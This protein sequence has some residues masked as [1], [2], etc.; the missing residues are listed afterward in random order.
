MSKNYFFK[1]DKILLEYYPEVTTIESIL[2]QLEKEEIIYL[3][4]L[5]LEKRYIEHFGEDYIMFCIGERKGNYYYLN[6]NIFENQYDFMYHIDLVEKLDLKLEEKDFYQG[7]FAKVI[8]LISD[9]VQKEVKIVPDDYQILE[10]GYIPISDYKK[11]ISSFPNQREISL[12]KRKVIESIIGNYFENLSSIEKYNNYVN[13]M[14]NKV[15]EK[16]DIIPIN[17]T[18]DIYKYELILLELTKMLEGNYSELEWQEKLIPIILLMYPKYVKCIKKVRIFIGNGHYKE[19]DYLL[20]DAEGNI[21]II[22]LKKPFEDCVLRKAEYRKN[23]IPGLELSGAIQQVQKYIYYLETF[24]SS[25]EDYINKKYFN[26]LNGLT[27]KIINPQAIII[28]GRSFNFD[29][30]QK[31]DYEIIRRQY[32]SLMEII[33][34]DDLILRLQ[35]TIR[36]LKR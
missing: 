26:E 28:C 5:T 6:K 9:C 36:L 4:A 7:R 30:R 10:S 19:I 35:T 15:L 20:I 29:Q 33:T 16:K 18:L 14:R 1:D 17:K 25:N 11:L 21:D 13:K 12:Y 8:Q 34:F 3:G 23:F 32:K 31:Q 2:N 24:K 27:I 22:E